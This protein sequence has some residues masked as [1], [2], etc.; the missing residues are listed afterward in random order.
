MQ[1]IDRSLC[2]TGFSFDR[3]GAHFAPLYSVQD[4]TVCGIKHSPSSAYDDLSAAQAQGQAPVGTKQTYCIRATAEIGCD[5]NKYESDPTCTDIVIA[6]ESSLSGSVSGSPSTG[7]APVK[8][9]IVTW[10]FVN[11]PD[12][13]GS[14]TTNSDGK[15]VETSTRTLD[16]N[17]QV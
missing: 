11:Y 2:E 3:E 5:S 14:A 6:W 12:I 10:S 4:S 17:I 7:L 9:V 13:G 16:V 1:W 8:D 15:F